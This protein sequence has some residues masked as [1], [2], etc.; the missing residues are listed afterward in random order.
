[1]CFMIIL[2]KK[3]NLVSLFF[4]FVIQE[5]HLTQT[6]HEGLQKLQAKE[7]EKARELLECVLRDPLI[8]SA[9]VLYFLCEFY[10][11]FNYVFILGIIK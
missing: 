7:Y 10:I 2:V 4:F 6:Y 3:Y 9:Q 1:M 5:F 8:A 11:F